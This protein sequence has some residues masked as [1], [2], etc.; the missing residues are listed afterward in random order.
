MIKWAAIPLLALAAAIPPLHAEPPAFS[1]PGP[2]T[3]DT[4]YALIA[5]NAA[6]P[7]TLELARTPDF[8]DARELYSG[9]NEA[10]FL[11]GLANGTYYL[12]LRNAAGEVS[13]PL[14]LSVVHQSLTRAL[15]LAGLGA[16]VFLAVVAA[17]VRG[18]R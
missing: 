16:L 10:Y 5:W 2:V 9:S 14:Q 7:A 1:D 13:A 4:G 6:D 11:S 18:E 12:S 17:I 8:S 15:W 3:S